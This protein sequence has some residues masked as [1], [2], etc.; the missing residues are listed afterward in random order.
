MIAGAGRLRNP[1]ELRQWGVRNRE[2][3][4]KRIHQSVNALPRPPPMRPIFP[5]SS[6]I[7]YYLP[8]RLGVS[9]SYC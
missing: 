5:V 8:T 3:L 2:E 9:K 1:A 7:C 4:D 6:Q